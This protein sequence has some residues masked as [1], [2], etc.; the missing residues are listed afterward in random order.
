MNSPK[1][2][3]GA[4]EAC[5]ICQ[6]GPLL[7]GMMAGASAKAIEMMAEEAERWGSGDPIDEH[8]I[9][10]MRDTAKKIQEPWL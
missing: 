1:N 9:Q 4:Q 7:K 3:D 8:F 5:A 10:F 2:P 6:A